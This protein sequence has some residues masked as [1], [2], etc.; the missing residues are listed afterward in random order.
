MEMRK[1]IRGIKEALKFVACHNF[2]PLEKIE[3]FDY[4]S[5]KMYLLAVDVQTFI[6]LNTLCFP[7]HYCVAGSLYLGTRANLD[8]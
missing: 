8:K 7:L 6:M 1:Y 5:F 4:F 2:L 3:H